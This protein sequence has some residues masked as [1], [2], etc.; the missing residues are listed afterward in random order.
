MAAPPRIGIVTIS[1]RASRGEYED[2]GGPAIERYLQDHL[3]SDWQPVR[4]LIHDDTDTIVRTLSNLCDDG[5][6][7]VI[8]TG[9]TGPAPRDVTPEATDIVCDKMMP[10]FGELMRM[11]S[12][13]YVPTAILT[14]ATAGIR[15]QSLVLNLPGKPTAIA[16]C[17]EVTLPAIPACIKL[18][19]GPMIV[20]KEVN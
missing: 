20:L 12:L 5:C 9:G 1:D 15:G 11:H 13:K 18:I 16:Q 17:L 4:R 7:W 14:R 6:H 19:G 10:G 2:L 3:A 8:T